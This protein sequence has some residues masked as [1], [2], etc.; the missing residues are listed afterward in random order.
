LRTGKSILSAHAAVDETLGNDRHVQARGTKS[1]LIVPIVRHGTACGMLY[2]ENDQLGGAFDAGRMALCEVLVAQMSIS[3]DNARLYANLEKIVDERT[4]ALEHA[5]ERVVEL[6]KNA[7]EVRMAGGFAHEMRNALTAAKMLLAAVHFEREGGERRSLCLDNGEALFDMY[8]MLERRVDAAALDEVVPILR[9][10]N[11]NEE[12]IHDV[13]GMI[14]A[15]IER[16]LSTTGMILDY[17][18]LSA[19]IAGESMFEVSYFIDALRTESQADFDKHGISLEV[20]IPFGARILGNDAH[21]YSILK[22]LVLNAR[23]ALVEVDRPEGR[24]IHIALEEHENGLRISV[25]DNAGGI[26]TDVAERIFEPFVSTKPNSGTG[27]GLGVVRKL[28]GLY[29]GTIDFESEMGRGTRF[30]ISLP[31]QETAQSNK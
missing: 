17:A 15:S 21:W 23:D 26:D 28:V 31:Q 27:L 4:R 7:T 18:K 10:L 30:V 13:L 1:L 6:E 29:N 24:K 25:E 11:A 22:N 9:Q 20:D 8:H 14:G 5:Q 2:L 12:K 19:E 16:A 3:I